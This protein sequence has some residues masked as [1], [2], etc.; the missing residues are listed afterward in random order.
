MGCSPRGHRGSDLTE[1]LTLHIISSGFVRYGVGQSSFPVFG[2][3]IF[4]CGHTVGF[5]GGTVVKNPPANAGDT[6]LDP[7]AGKNP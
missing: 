4:H 7:W 1:Q 5:P 3:M 6:G 2:P